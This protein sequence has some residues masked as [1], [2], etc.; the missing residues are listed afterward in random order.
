MEKLIFWCCLGGVSCFKFSISVVGLFFLCISFSFF[1]L[2][3]FFMPLGHD[4]V[5]ETRCNWYL[6]DINKYFLSNKKSSE[7]NG[8][9]IQ[10]RSI[11]MC[12]VAT[13]C[14]FS[15]GVLDAARVICMV[16]RAFALACNK[17]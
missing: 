2:C 3:A 5:A 10:A 8:M 9:R 13:R 16:C 1:W 17:L 6:H 7:G 15:L 14:S 11:Y 12:G 4:V